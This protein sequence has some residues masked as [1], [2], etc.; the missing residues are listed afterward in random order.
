MALEPCRARGVE[1]LLTNEGPE[2][3]ARSMR[4]GRRFA[5]LYAPA[6]GAQ[7]VCEISVLAGANIVAEPPNRLERGTP[8]RDVGRH[9]KSPGAQPEC[10]VLLHSRP[11]VLVAGRGPAVARYRLVLDPA[12][13]QGRRFPRLGLEVAIEQL[14]ARI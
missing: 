1:Q 11:H 6:G 3:L 4:D 5:A 9:R 12:T 10:V 14:L 13:D 2:R 8:D 7:S